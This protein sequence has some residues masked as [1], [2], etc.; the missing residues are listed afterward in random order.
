MKNSHRFYSKP[1]GWTF[2][3]VWQDSKEWAVGVL[4]VSGGYLAFSTLEGE[5]RL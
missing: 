3:A 2:L 4:R 1:D 5:E